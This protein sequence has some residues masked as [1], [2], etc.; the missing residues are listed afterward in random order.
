MVDQLNESDILYLYK[1]FLKVLPI[2]HY[3][4]F[5]RPANI[6]PI[7]LPIAPIAAPQNRL[8]LKAT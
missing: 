8:S 2:P 3:P 1:M 5:L 7:I 4:L 6:P